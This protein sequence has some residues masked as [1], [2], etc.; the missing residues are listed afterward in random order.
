MGLNII[1]LRRNGFTDEEI[2]ELKAAYRVLYRNALPFQDVLRMLAS[3][4]PG[5]HVQ[6]LH[7]FIAETRR[8]IVME[9]RGG[10]VSTLRLVNSPQEAEEMRRAG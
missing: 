1:G 3:D 4:F 9:R 2:H 7:R 6:Y 10:R 5:R 8:G